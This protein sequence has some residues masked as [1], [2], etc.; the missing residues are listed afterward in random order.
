MKTGLV[1]FRNNLRIDDNPALN[2]ALE[3]N[4][5]VILLYVYDERIFD[6]K[7]F[8]I[9]RIGGHRIRFMLQTIEDLSSTLE[10]HDL[11]LH[12]CYGN[13]LTKIQELVSSNQID[14]VYTQYEIGYEEQHDVDHIKT[15]TTVNTFES[16]TLFKKETLGFDIPNLP[17]VFTDFRKKAQKYGSVI[18]PINFKRG[19]AESIELPEEN[20][21]HKFAERLK[22]THKNAAFMYSGGESIG[23]DRLYKYVWKDQFITTY[24]KTRNN[25]IGS[26]YSS[27]FSP[28]LS[29]GSLSPRRIYTE[30]EKFE[31]EVK[32]ND[33]TYWL[34][35]ELLWREFF[36]WTAYN[37]PASIFKL[38]GF[39]AIETQQQ[40]KNENF[41]QWAN[42]NTVNEFINANMNELN[43]TGFMSNRGRQIV[44]SYLIYDLKVDWRLGAAYFEKMLLDYDPSANYGNWTYIAGV[45][46][47]PRGG[48]HFNVE[49][50]VEHYDPNYEYTNLWTSKKI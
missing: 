1:W 40:F 4:D 29:N 16:S 22:Q 15:F 43:K 9:D 7:Q 45:G 10:A 36:K 42:G 48:R 41:N 25:L 18:E 50:Q 31:K 49:K 39:S 20:F 28:W 12:T 30:I 26:S 3:E 19:K 34:K 32:K 27:K 5:K 35:F 14:E 6:G 21:M 47:D 38:H 46:N 2:N 11:F 24:K 13:P 44:A 17:I 37:N 33:S 23:K 8:N